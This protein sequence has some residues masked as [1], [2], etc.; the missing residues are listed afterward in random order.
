MSEFKIVYGRSGSGKTTYIFNEIKE[1]VKDNNKIFIIVPEQYSFSAEKH[2]LDVLSE[3]S[4]INAEVLTLSRMADRVIEETIGKTKTHISKVGKAMILYDV[5]ENKK[6]SLNFLKSSDKNLDIAIN[7]INELKKHNIKK[8]TLDS[9]ISNVNDSYLKLKLK[10]V[11]DVL[12]GYESK[13]EAKYLDEGDALSKLAEN[14]EGVSDFNQSIIYI[15]EFAGFTTSEY[16]IIEKLCTLA[17]EITVTVC[18][19]LVEKV[20]NIDESI[21]YFNEITAEKLLEIAKRNGCFIEKIDLSIPKKFNSEELKVLEERLYPFAKESVN[22]IQKYGKKTQD[23][24]LFVAKNPYS[25]IEYALNKIIELVKT[26]GYR[27]RDFAI[28]SGNMDSYVNN[29]R[30][31]FEKYEIPVFIDEKKDVNH[32]ILMKYIISLLNVLSSNYSYDAM[33][34][35]IKSGIL[36]ITDDEIFE[37]ETYVKKWGIRGA[38]WYK[39]DFEFEEKSENQDRIN[40]VRKRIIEPILDFKNSLS[41]EKKVR[42]IVKNLYEFINKHQI[43]SAIL[44]KADRLEEKGRNETAEEFRAGIQIFFDV[45]D[46]MY[47]IFDEE[48]MSYDRFNKLLQIGITNSEFGLIPATFDQVLFGDIDRTKTKDVKVLFVLGL[49]DGVIPKILK[50]EGFLNDK[51]RD[52]LKENN[53]EIAKNSVEALYED[54]FNIYKTITMPSD[55]LFLSYSSQDSEGKALRYSILLTQ[56]KKIFSDL[57]EDSDVVEEKYYI[58]TKDASFDYAIEKYNEFLDDKDIE[59]EWKEVLAWYNEHEKERLDA[60][61]E[62]AKYSN[63]PEIIAGDKLQKMYGSNLKTSVSRLE[64]YRRCPFS[65]HLKYGLKLQEEEELK[66]RSL[67]TGNFMHDVIDTVFTKI[68]ENELDVK[69]IT[70]E[71]LFNIVNNIINEKLGINKNYIFSSSAKNIVLTRRLKKTVYQS[72]EYIVE[73]LKN[74]SFELYGHEIEFGNQS[75]FKPLKIDLPNGKEVTV[76]G[77]IDRVDIAKLDDKTVFRIIDY[78]SS[79]KDVDLNQFMSGIQ[80]QLLTYLDEIANQKNMEGV[81]VLYFNLL[82]T[83]VKAN[84][85]MSDEELKKELNKNFK[86]KGIVV[87]DVKIVKMMD[88]KLGPSMSSEQ[89]PIY[90][91]KDENISSGRSFA[92]DKEG[93]EK[94]QKYTKHIISEIAKDIYSGDISLKPFKMNKKTPCEYCEYKAICNFD[95]KMEKNEYNYISKM[96]KE[97]IIEEIKRRSN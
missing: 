43:D 72:I 91:D 38:K 81:G 86:M 32:N 56:I 64:Q 33:F 89:I 58:S 37:I 11:E 95:P 97:E 28:V 49:N 16:T 6:D 27:Y 73:Q 10:D 2:L 75:E 1:K 59:E 39:D 80:I 77:K 3:N 85:P 45:L 13:I 5:L 62:G 23:I 46:E 90:L 78:K 87:S 26:K 65:F 25:E 51:D 88:H 12:E 30:T 47:E 79:V 94:L 82:D 17:K 20:E 7:M 8:E 52:I 48:T 40:E 76:T 93:F 83:I 84:K 9:V 4:S 55:K 71:E 24:S 21:F 57:S 22:S 53:A 63:V 42:D 19:D 67:D 36:D 18:T 70:K 54:Q 92:I 35:Y 31:S 74:S 60:T 69:T 15:D 44:S 14:I 96:K 29:A 41:G 61:V 68:E 66:I 34:S 50:D